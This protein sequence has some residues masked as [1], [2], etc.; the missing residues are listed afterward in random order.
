MTYLAIS[1]AESR[2]AIINLIASYLRQGLVAVLPTDTIYGF[3]CSA[4]NQLAIRRIYRLKKRDPRKPLIILVSGW[5]MLRRYTK[6]SPSQVKLVKRYCGNSERPTTIILPASKLISPELLSESGG[7]AVRLPKSKLLIKIIEKLQTPIVSTSLNLSGQENISDV[8]LI[9]HYF[10]QIT[11]RPDLV[12][13]AGMDRRRRP[14]RLLDLRN[15]AQP[16]V[17]RK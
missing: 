9:N 7:V 6:L 15:P 11:K 8:R 1:R 2:P 4:T 12:V 13:D 10:P 16:L 3:S 5:A 17:L 14:S